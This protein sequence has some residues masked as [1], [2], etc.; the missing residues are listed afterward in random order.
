VRDQ[1]YYP[2]AQV[3]EPLLHFFSSVMSI[4][5]RTRTPP[6]NLVEP[7]QLALRGAAGDQALYEVRTMEELAGASLARQR[8]LLFLFSVFAGI[9]LL[10]A[11]IGI[12]GVLAYLTGQ[13]MPEIG[14]RLALGASVRNVVGLVLRQCLKMVFAGLAA[15]IIGAYVAGRVLQR[16][17]QGMQ[18]IHLTTFTIM[19]PI[20]LAAALAAGF[21]PAMRASRVDPVKAL[22]QE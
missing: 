8:F 11:S 2:F 10:L 12:Y 20:L 7:L 16:L 3:P 17:V 13:R 4:A 1:L 14:V 5:I 6:L 22:R 19:I 18:P 9:A 21:V 15:G